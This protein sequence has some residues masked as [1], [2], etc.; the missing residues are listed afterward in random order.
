M[1]HITV[2]PPTKKQQ[3]ERLRVAAYCRVSSNREDQT[4]SYEAQVR[5]FSTLYENSETEQLIG[6]YADEGISGTSLGKR[7]E[8]NRLL[9]DCRSGKV[10]RI[11]TK[12]ISRFARNTKDCL[13]CI[14]ELKN[15]GISIAFEKENIDTA[16]ISDEMMITIMGGLAQ[17]ESQSISNNC[18]WGIHKKMAAG[19]FRHA[20]IPY[21]Y[22]KDDESG[23]L[24]VDHEKAE[25]IRRI[26]DLYINGT[27][28]RKIT[29]MLNDEGITS[30]TG[31]KWNQKTVL[32][33]LSQEKYTGNTLWQKTYGEFMGV[34][35]RP[36]HGELPKYYLTDT[37]EAI[38]SKEVFEAAQ[39]VKKNSAPKSSHRQETPFRK[40]V[41]C[42]HC[43]HTYRYISSK[44]KPY[45]QCG[46]RYDIGNPCENTVFDDKEL[47]IAF[48]ALC[49]KLHT[50]GKE[51]LGKCSAQLDELNV[52]KQG[53][54]VNTVELYKAIADLRDQKHRLSQLLTKRFISQEKYDEQIDSIDIKINRVENDIR[55]NSEKESIDNNEISD[56]IDIFAEYNGTEVSRIE[57]LESVIE[58][59]SVKDG[60]FTFRLIGG[61]EFNERIGAYGKQK[62]TLRI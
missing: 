54:T 5:Y 36:N 20:K 50:F 21:G 60:I 19:T 15:L 29:L 1:A 30:P 4:H 40:K 16:R 34:Q 25:V 23:G 13:K 62:D 56:I 10:D 26:F 39:A 22:C 61:I 9:E 31:I 28:A 35:F 43:G 33:I 53:G 17:E 49:D 11:V 8:L 59:I 2:I 51:I 57:I 55:A 47:H 37:H 45:W 32:K 48:T 44:G 14:R 27:G 58:S 7:I 12:S 42:A 6:I 18:R 24:V 38:I 52:L 3:R 41:I 46:Y